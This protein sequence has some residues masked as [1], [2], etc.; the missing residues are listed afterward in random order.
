MKRKEIMEKLAANMEKW[1]KVED[2][3]VS[4]TGQ[5]IAKTQNPVVRLVMEII[6]NDSQRHYHVQQLIIDS[7]KKTAINITP[8][9]IGEVWGMIKKHI[10]IEN[11]TIQL[12]EE[13]LE[14]LKSTKMVVQ[15]YLLEYLMEDEKKHA[16]MLEALENVKQG[17]YPYG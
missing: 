12:A 13:S 4:S 10:E 6:Q 15:Q 17:L 14:S 3:S 9:E 8:E 2:A 5:I 11:K 1:Q 7:L 16:K